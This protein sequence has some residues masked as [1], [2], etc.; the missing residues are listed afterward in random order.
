VVAFF[1]AVFFV[2]AFLADPFLVTEDFAELAFFFFAF[3]AD[4]DLVDFFLEVAL[5]AIFNY[6]ED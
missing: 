5:R 1:T 4:S 2:A 6:P 3:E